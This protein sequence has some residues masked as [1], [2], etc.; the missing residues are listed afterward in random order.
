MK[1]C[2]HKRKHEFNA[3]NWYKC[4][5]LSA[6]LSL[7]QLSPAPHAKHGKLCSASSES[8]QKDFQTVFCHFASLLNFFSV[9]RMNEAEIKQKWIPFPLFRPSPPP[10]KNGNNFVDKFVC[11][12]CW[13]HSAYCHTI[14]GHRGEKNVHYVRNPVDNC[15]C[16]IMCNSYMVCVCVCD[17][18]DKWLHSTDSCT[19]RIRIYRFHFVGLLIRSISPAHE[20]WSNFRR[21]VAHRPIHTTNT[22]T[23]WNYY[24]EYAHSIRTI[25]KMKWESIWCGRMAA[26]TSFVYLYLH[27]PAYLCPYTIAPRY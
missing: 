3:S 23:N 12:H 26:L 16:R 4:H 22:R 9:L 5:S 19:D 7:A 2:F 17:A 8:I 21:L 24:V 6:Q 11:S 14:N 18:D 25:L 20:T 27:V 10:P 15:C 13:L 1:E